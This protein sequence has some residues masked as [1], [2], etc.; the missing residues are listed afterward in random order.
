MREAISQHV[1]AKVAVE[2]QHAD[3]TRREDH[4]DQDSEDSAAPELQ[5]V[6][7][8][9]A[10]H[11]IGKMDQSTKPD[12]PQRRQHSNDGG[13]QDHLDIVEL[14]GAKP[15]LRLGRV[16]LGSRH[17]STLRDDQMSRKRLMTFSDS[18]SWS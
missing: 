2:Q 8:K 18:S 5:Q 1:A 11:D 9:L 12:V 3:R 13:E 17:P 6:P 16:D 7:F 14:V 4:W 15:Q 10:K